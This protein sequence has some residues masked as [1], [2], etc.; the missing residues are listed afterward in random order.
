MS[1]L[2]KIGRVIQA[3]TNE[4]TKPESFAKGEEFEQYVRDVVFPKDKYELIHRSH[5]H[6]ENKEDYVGTSLLPDFGFKCIE[7]GRMFYVEVKFREGV[8]FKNKIEWC[9]P[10]QLK[11]YKKLDEGE[12]PVFLALGLGKKSSKPEEIFIIPLSK[13]EYT[14]FYDSFLDRYSFYVGKPVFSSFLWKLTQ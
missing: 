6:S 10:Y 11:R 4:L 2:K 1:L 3:A 13:V 5:S 9:K 8:Y 14:G 7:T 12:H